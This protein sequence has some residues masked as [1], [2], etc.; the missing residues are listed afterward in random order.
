MKVRIIEANGFEK[1][2]AVFDAEFI[3][4]FLKN[5]SVDITNPNLTLGPGVYGNSTTATLGS[6]TNITYT[7]TSFNTFVN[8]SLAKT[9]LS[10]S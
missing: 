6:G 5:H 4:E 10:T 7:D 3:E 2:E 8:D 9:F 1:K